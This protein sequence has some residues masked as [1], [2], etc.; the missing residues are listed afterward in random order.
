MSKLK[1]ADFYYGA[2]L[3]TLF[4]NGITPMLIEG[5]VDRQVYD[6]T[7]DQAN[8]RLFVKYRSTG[9]DG[10]N[11]YKSWTFVLSANDIAEL[12]TFLNEG[13]N[14]SLA[15]VCGNGGFNDS[16]YAVLHADELESLLISGKES[17]TISRAKG[18]KAFRVSI[19]H[20]RDNAMK[21]PSNRLF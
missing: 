19:G 10:A 11:E 20:G 13:K 3:S 5:G 4:N 8:F 18:E 16:E 15:L 2:V 17:I 1:V 7:T 12:R 6:F 9:R 14:V 21:I